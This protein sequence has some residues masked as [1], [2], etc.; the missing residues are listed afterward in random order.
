[1]CAS[2]DHMA[3]KAHMHTIGLIK[4]I[5]GRDPKGLASIDMCTV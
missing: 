5:T 3:S 2:K 4:T 1:M